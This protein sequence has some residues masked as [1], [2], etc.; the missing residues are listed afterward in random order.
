MVALRAEHANPEIVGTV[1]KRVASDSSSIISG[2]KAFLL[3][4]LSIVIFRI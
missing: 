2:L 3:A 4:A 1:E